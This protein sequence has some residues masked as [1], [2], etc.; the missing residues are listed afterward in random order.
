MMPGMNCRAFPFR[1]RLDSYTFPSLSHSSRPRGV[2]SK[3]FQLEMS[4]SVELRFG[5]YL[6][7]SL[8]GWFITMNIYVSLFS[9][10]A[11]HLQGDSQTNPSDTVHEK[12]TTNS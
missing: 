4:G 9:D 11:L 3:E 10:Y 7:V 5:R 6:R 1:A 2:E 8:A 12:T